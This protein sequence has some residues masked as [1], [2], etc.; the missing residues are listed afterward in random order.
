MDTK[1]N[2]INLYNKLTSAF[3]RRDNHQDYFDILKAIYF[4]KI[5]RITNI[6]PLLI[7]DPE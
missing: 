4:N 7:S 2:C 5:I 1:I 6:K 3:D